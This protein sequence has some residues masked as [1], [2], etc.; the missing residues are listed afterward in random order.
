MLAHPVNY[1]AVLTAALVAS[2]FG[3][4]WYRVFITRW[5]DALRTT[6]EQLLPLGRQS[7][8]S[9]AIA[10]VAELLMAAVMAHLVPTLGPVSVL[11]GLMMAG[12]CWLGFVLTTV[13]VD[14]AYSGGSRGL[15]AV[16]SWHWLG[17]MLVM[18]GVIGAF[19]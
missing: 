7:L 14:N 6:R 12:A 19:G 8:R 15:P 5:A 11:S 4:I 1:L 16:A 18:G 3:A 2:A 17:V 13:V 9:L 10:F